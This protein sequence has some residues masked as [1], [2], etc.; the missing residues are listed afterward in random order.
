MPF[1]CY[2]CTYTF[3]L[4]QKLLCIT[5]KNNGGV[6]TLLDSW[7]LG[8]LASWLLGFSASWLLGFSASGCFGFLLVYAAFGGFLVVVFRILCIP[9]SSLA[10]GVLAFAAFRWFMRLLAAL[11]FCILCFPSSSPGAF[12]FAPFHWFLVLASRIISITS[13][14]LFESS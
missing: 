7:L 5:L 13:P 1:S 12:A 2:T 10:G 3:L 4:S 9:S 6:F 14:S 8:F 11:A